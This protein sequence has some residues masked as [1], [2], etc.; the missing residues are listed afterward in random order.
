MG[1]FVRILRISRTVIVSLQLLQTMSIVIQNLKNEHSIC[2][3]TIE[4]CS[5]ESI[6]W[7]LHILLV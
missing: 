5:T 2:K 6:F 3:R 4:M 1:E 7:P